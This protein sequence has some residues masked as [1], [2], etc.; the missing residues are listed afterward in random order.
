LFHGH[1]SAI[2]ELLQ[3]GGVGDP[4]E[5]LWEY[6]SSWEMDTMDITKFAILFFGD[7]GT[8]E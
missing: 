4:A 5:E 3:Q 8:F 2:P 6:I 7:L 1:I